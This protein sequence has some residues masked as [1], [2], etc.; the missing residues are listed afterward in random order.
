MFKE[1][2]IVFVFKGK[3]QQGQLLLWE[4]R[5]GTWGLQRALHPGS[6]FENHRPGTDQVHDF[7]CGSGNGGFCR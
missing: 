2:P 5:L 6:G 7:V 4:I 1:T 3:D